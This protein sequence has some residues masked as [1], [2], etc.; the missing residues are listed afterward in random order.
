[1]LN[2]MLRKRDIVREPET[3]HLKIE[4]TQPRFKLIS[5]DLKKDVKCRNVLSVG[6]FQSDLKWRCKQAEHKYLT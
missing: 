4:S 5:W 6:P 3:E 2:S 1:M